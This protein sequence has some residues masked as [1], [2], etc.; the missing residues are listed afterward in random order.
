MVTK[1]FLEEEYVKNGKTTY[2]IAAM[3]GC[4]AKNIYYHLDKYGIERRNDFV[5]HDITGQKFG[6]LTAIRIIDKNKY[7]NIWECQCE[8]G[9]IVHLTTT[10]LTSRNRITRSCGCLV[11]EKTKEKHHLWTGY[12]KI[13][14]NRWCSIKQCAKHRNKGFYITIDFAWDL[15]LKQNKCCALTGMAL[16]IDDASIDRIDSLLDYTEDNVWWVHKDINKIKASTNTIEFIL[17]CKSIVDYRVNKIIPD[18][19]MYRPTY[20]LT[21]SFWG[22]TLYNAKRRKI[23]VLISIEEALHQFIKQRGLCYLTGLPI[24]IHLSKSKNN[25][26]NTGSLDRINSNNDYTYDNISWCHKNINQSRKDLDLNYYI[27][28]CEQVVNFN[29]KGGGCQ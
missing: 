5:V 7:G 11:H 25:P 29:T 15:F 19:S 28:L 26:K 24:T 3:V 27:K 2:Q 12:G 4:S 21:K 8:C 14:G 18:T 20:E 16:D 1:E 13:S 9:N 23:D 10:C 6:K 22:Q 17:M